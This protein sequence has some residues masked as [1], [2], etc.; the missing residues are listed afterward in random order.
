MKMLPTDRTKGVDLADP[1]YDQLVEDAAKLNGGSV[2]D[3]DT[4]VRILLGEIAQFGFSVL[5]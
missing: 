5:G 3:I 2:D 1:Y 4:E